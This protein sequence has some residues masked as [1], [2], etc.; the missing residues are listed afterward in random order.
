MHKYKKSFL[1][2]AY[3]M[4]E[5]LIV[6]G[7]IGVIAALVMPMVISA[8]PS[9]YESMHKKGDYELE[10][11]ISDIVNSEEYYER[12]DIVDTQNHTVRHLH[13]LQ[14][15]YPVNINGQMVGSN[16]PNSDEAKQKFCRIMASKFNRMAN[17]PVNCSE[18]AAFDLG[19]QGAHRPSF[20][21][22]DGIQW[23]IPI[24]N[25]LDGN[26][27]IM[28]K[29]SVDSSSGPNCAYVSPEKYAAFPADEIEQLTFVKTDR[30]ACKKPDIYLYIITPGG[31]LYKEEATSDEVKGRNE[32]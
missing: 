31:K 15:T 7:I 28:Y 8:I 11:V 17:T 21:S 30:E 27:I 23:V 19:V 5:I 2:K 29:S 16:N 24:S 26:H 32:D 22:I 20:V 4:A 13:G 10:H 9:R 3:T 6:L 1:K 12:L 14:N 25:F 18:T